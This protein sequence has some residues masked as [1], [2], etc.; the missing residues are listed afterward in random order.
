[1]RNSLRW[2]RRKDKVY[3]GTNLYC[4]S[5]D[6]IC[7]IKISTG[8]W[9]NLLVF[10]VIHGSWLTKRRRCG[11]QRNVIET[12]WFRDEWVFICAA[13]RQ[14]PASC[15]RSLPSRID[16]NRSEIYLCKWVFFAW[17]RKWQTT[18]TR[19]LRSINGFWIS[20]LNDDWIQRASFFY[21]SNCDW[22]VCWCPFAQR[23]DC[24]RYVRCII[25]AILRFSKIRM[26]NVS[27]RDY[28]STAIIQFR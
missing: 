4:I 7:N 27:R 25:F 11:S 6:F 24:S 15:A 19:C 5:L 9:T 16:W 18:V 21:L 2:R 28:K 22:L 8:K 10:V 12:E 20:T 1:M 3:G 17:A 26:R 14:V 23:L 13:S